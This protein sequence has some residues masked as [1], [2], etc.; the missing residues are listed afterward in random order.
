MTYLDP[1]W[2]GF[3][4]YKW[5]VVL[6]YLTYLDQFCL[7]SLYTD[8]VLFYFIY[9]TDDFEGTLL[10]Y[11]QTTLKFYSPRIYTTLHYF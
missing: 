1:V 5:S 9:F 2:F 6:L 3:P 10:S 8:E 11:P 7:I 4:L